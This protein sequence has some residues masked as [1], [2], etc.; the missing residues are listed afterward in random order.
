M[1]QSTQL[2]PSETSVV[3]TERCPICWNDPMTS[4]IETICG[5]AFDKHCLDTWLRDHTTCPMCR[6][7]LKEDA[8][9]PVEVAVSF[10]VF[11]PYSDVNFIS[12]RTRTIIVIPR[13]R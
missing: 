9:G 12:M 13:G 10:R 7:V 11:I 2:K 3:K 5:H 4:R 1:I 8:E 6:K